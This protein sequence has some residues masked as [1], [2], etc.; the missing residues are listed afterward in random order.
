MRK[1]Q[2]ISMHHD[3]LHAFNVYT[4]RGMRRSTAQFLSDM[5]CLSHFHWEMGKCTPLPT[6]TRVSWREVSQYAPVPVPGPVLITFQSGVVAKGTHSISSLTYSPILSASRLPHP[7]VFLPFLHLLTLEPP[8]QQTSSCP[9]SLQPLA[10]LLIVSTLVLKAPWGPALGP[11]HVY[12][13]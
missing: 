7:Q 1:D 2:G 5:H 11:F 13:A 4:L 10:V 6:Q 9:C 12:N 3:S 8:F